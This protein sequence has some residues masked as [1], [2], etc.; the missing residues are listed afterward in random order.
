MLGSVLNATY[1]LSFLIVKASNEKG[2]IMKH[3]R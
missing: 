2:I 1:V 3:E